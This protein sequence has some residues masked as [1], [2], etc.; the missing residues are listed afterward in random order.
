MSMF[1]YSLPTLNLGQLQKPEHEAP[2]GQAQEN[3]GAQLNCHLDRFG[4]PVRPRLAIS[5]S[6]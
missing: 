6:G 2:V 3:A 4:N 5:L 1:A